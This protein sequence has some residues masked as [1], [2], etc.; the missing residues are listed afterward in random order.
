MSEG[1]AKTLR[2]TGPWPLALTARASERCLLVC[3]Q[4][5]PGVRRL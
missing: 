1:D 2:C 4:Q 3:P 5:G